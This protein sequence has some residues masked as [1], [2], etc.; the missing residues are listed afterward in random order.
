MGVHLGYIEKDNYVEIVFFH[1]LDYRYTLLFKLI[2]I[3]AN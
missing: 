2:N 3:L 1:I